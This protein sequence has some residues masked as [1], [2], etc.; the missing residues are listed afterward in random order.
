MELSKEQKEKIEN[1]LRPYDGVMI[2]PICQ[3]IDWN[4][5]PNIFEYPNY[6]GTANR[7][8]MPNRVF[9]FII[10]YCE[11]C[12]YCISFSAIE[13]GVVT[14]RVLNQPQENVKENVERHS[15]RD[16]PFLKWINKG[17][18]DEKLI[19][20]LSYVLIFIGGIE[21]GSNLTYPIILA[22]L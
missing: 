9:P 14:N 8:P 20:L 17:T 1:A 16:A 18:R 12:N 11:Q 10:L 19:L 22:N 13:L 6:Q 3:G 15:W 7:S 4:L 21:V 2:C 5:N